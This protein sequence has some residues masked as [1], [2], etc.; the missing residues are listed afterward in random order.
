MPVY[1]SGGSAFSYCGLVSGI[2]GVAKWL[3]CVAVTDGERPRAAEQA[4]DGEDSKPVC[5]LA[6]DVDEHGSAMW[7][8]PRIHADLKALGVPCGLHRVARLM[9][10]AAICP[11]PARRFVVTTDSDHALRVQALLR[12]WLKTA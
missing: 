6:A 11:V 1:P 2:K 7:G 3:L 5:R 12:H 10:K 9:R 4:T 8:S